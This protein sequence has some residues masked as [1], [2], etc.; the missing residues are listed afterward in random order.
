MFFILCIPF[1]YLLNQSIRVQ[2]IQRCR[3]MIFD[4]KGGAPQMTLLHTLYPISYSDKLADATVEYWNKQLPSLYK[5]C[6]SLTRNVADAEDVMQ[7]TCLK[8]LS[9]QQK[10][11]AIPQQEAYIIRTA[12]NTWI[13]TLRRRNY[14]N[15]YIQQY[16]PLIDESSE[17][18]SLDMELAIQQ[19]ITLLSPW[20]QAVFMLRDLLCYSAADTAQ[21]LETTEGAVKA[22][23][24]RAR[25]VLTK[26]A[27]SSDESIQLPED[28]DALLV[29][30]HYRQA[31][32]TGDACKIVQFT[33]MRMNTASPEAHAVAIDSLSVQTKHSTPKTVVSSTAQ[34]FSP[35]HKPYSLPSQRMRVAA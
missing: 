25:T 27:D 32:Y 16:Q 1:A 17:Y 4:H 23:L 14:V 2:N 35:Y 30:H 7:D 21:M 11:I 6:L 18:C 8:I 26:Q 24:Y 3:K 12:R 31:L 33:L 20:Q 28:A 15:D 10:G 22:A 29:I 13:D 5:Y 9:T 19:L 34:S